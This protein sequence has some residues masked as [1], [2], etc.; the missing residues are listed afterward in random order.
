[1][2]SSFNKKN[3]SVNLSNWELLTHIQIILNAFSKWPFVSGKPLNRTY[4]KSIVTYTYVIL[5]K[6][7]ISIHTRF[8]DENYINVPLTNDR[9]IGFHSKAIECYKEISKDFKNWWLNIDCESIIVVGY[10]LGGV[11]AQYLSM[12]L[13]SRSENKIN[14]CVNF[15]TP[16]PG[17]S[18]YCDIFE[19]SKIKL[20]NVYIEGD[21]YYTM[22][23]FE[24]NT[25]VRLNN[26]INIKFKANRIL[27]NYRG[28]DVFIEFLTNLLLSDFINN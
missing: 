2:N 23:N 22:P 9:N 12:S 10:G 18:A 28:V 27:Q 14:M 5:D 24:K 21:P 25:Y 8:D 20:I 17:D 26:E 15:G 4:L 11:I 7:Y 19:K 13:R 16:K 6:L 1:M 3:S